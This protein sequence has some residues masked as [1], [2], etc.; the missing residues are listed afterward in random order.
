MPK[1]RK[2]T[3][4]FVEQQV[5]AR[6]R[7]GVEVLELVDRAE[8]EA[9]DDLAEAAARLLVELLDLRRSSIPSTTRSP[10][11]GSR[12]SRVTTSGT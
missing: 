3:R 4:P 12:D 1:S 5:V 2:A 9:E 10:A 11:R 6:V 7:V 8:V